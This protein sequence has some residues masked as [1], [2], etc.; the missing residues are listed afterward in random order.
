[1]KWCGLALVEI[2]ICVPLLWGL[3]TPS[4]NI[5]SACYY[6]WGISPEDISIPDGYV[7]T[8]A[9]VNLYG[10]SSVSDSS[11]G[12]LVVYLLDNPPIGWHE[13]QDIPGVDH[14]APHGCRLKPDYIDRLQGYETLSYRLSAI[15]HAN[16]WAWRVYERPFVFKLGETRSVAFSSAMLELI[17]YVGNA[18]PFGIGLDPAGDDDFILGGMSL[19]L[20]V[21]SFHGEPDTK[22]MRLTLG[23]T[24]SPPILNTPALRA[25]DEG[26]PLSIPLTAVDPDGDSVAISCDSL[27]PGAKFENGVLSWTPSYETASSDSAMP[28]TVYITATDGTLSTSRTLVIWV[29]NTNRAPLL[30]GLTLLATDK[31]RL[32]YHVDASDPDGDSL[33]CTSTQLPP[34]A[35]LDGE[36]RIINWETAGLASGVYDIGIEVSD[37]SLSHARTFSIQINAIDRPIIT[38]RQSGLRS[39]DTSTP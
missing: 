22:R 12:T 9:V 18:T 35:M 28:F 2:L 16:S 5:D 19:T 8:D 7:I 6:T 23:D 29:V 38:D 32:I 3:N 34:Q 13:N 15:N 31:S 27:P 25:V 26:M 17:D 1:M 20:T 10:L 21:E 36:T 33:T 24:N 4:I 37:G 14:F 30:E 39:K 11:A